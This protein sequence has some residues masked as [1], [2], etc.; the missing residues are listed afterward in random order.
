MSEG[1]PTEFEYGEDLFDFNE[2]TIQEQ[3]ELYHTMFRGDVAPKYREARQRVEEAHMWSRVQYDPRVGKEPFGSIDQSVMGAI[4]DHWAVLLVHESEDDQSIVTHRQSLLSQES[5][6]YCALIQQQLYR[7]TSQ[8]MYSE[9]LKSFVKPV[10]ARNDKGLNAAI[11]TAMRQTTAWKQTLP[12]ESEKPKEEG[13]EKRVFG[14]AKV[15]FLKQKRIP[16]S[17]VHVNEEKPERYRL[18]RYNLNNTK[19]VGW[20]PTSFTF[21]C[22]SNAIPAVCLDDVRNRCVIVV[23]ESPLLLNIYEYR[24]DQTKPS[25]VPTQVA[26]PSASSDTQTEFPTLCCNSSFRGNQYV[27]G[28]GTGIC[29]L[30]HTHFP[31]HVFHHTFESPHEQIAHMVTCATFGVQQHFAMYV[32]TRLG[33]VWMFDYSQ[34]IPVSRGPKYIFSMILP[35]HQVV[36]VPDDCP[37]QKGKLC[38]MTIGEVAYLDGPA[39]D[40][41]TAQHVGRA[42]LVD[43]PIGIGMCGSLIYALSKCGD[44]ILENVDPSVSTLPKDGMYFPATRKTCHTF[45]MTPWYH[46][47]Y[48]LADRVFVLYPDGIIRVWN[49]LQV[50]E[51]FGMEK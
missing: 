11:A 21:C 37:T 18:W 12:L 15:S 31:K 23:H 6:E 44:V 40:M 29:V 24:M 17:D 20:M 13:I 7:C 50:D 47:I 1:R 45:W 43:R 36:Y 10:K 34:A 4:N 3:V 28:Y 9:V 22:W 26:F 42:V 2:L 16:E 49:A 25:Y 27:I 32:G 46:A 33:H 14:H 41:H 51:M 19:K 38:A 35:V 8:R 5:S 48:T 30:D 39:I